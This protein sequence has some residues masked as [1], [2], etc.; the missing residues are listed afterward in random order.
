[1]HHTGHHPS[2]LK[3]FHEVL[4]ER[5]ATRHFSNEPV[6]PEVISAILADA[7]QA[8]SGYN[9]QPWRF[10]VVREAGAKARLRAAAFD[11]EKIT[12]APVVIVAFSPR[13]AWRDRIDEVFAESVRRGALP[14][15]GAEKA[16]QTAVGFV[17]AFDPATWINRHVMIAFTTLMYAAEAH[18]LDTAPMEGFDAAAV[19]QVFGMPEDTEVVAL[20]AL[21]RMR[22]PD[23]EFPGRF[24]VE[25]IAFDGN[26]QTPWPA[27]EEEPHHN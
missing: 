26:L 14:A 21:G 19:R 15:D 10:L 23:S 3:S 1:M 8:P 7:A 18:G 5:R 16:K 27:V 9:L 2:A 13:H 6:P 4:R 24:P 20:L 22:E 17:G 25:R 12:E 11:Q